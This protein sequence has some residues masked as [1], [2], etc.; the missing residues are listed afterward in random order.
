MISQFQNG[1]LLCSKLEMCGVI[2]SLAFEGDNA[3]SICLRMN[4]G[5]FVSKWIQKFK[6][7]SSNWMVFHVQS[8]TFDSTVKAECLVHENCG[9]TLG[10]V[11]VAL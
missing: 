4:D 7:V 2:W 10:D 8:I 9:A 11:A 1:G 3:I 5:L 6:C